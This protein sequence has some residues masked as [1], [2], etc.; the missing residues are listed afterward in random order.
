MPMESLLARVS[1]RWKITALVAASSLATAVL[2]RVLAGLGGAA[3]GFAVGLVLV[4]GFS[5]LAWWA[6]GLIVK[7]LGALRD[8]ARAIADGD[9]SAA[10][11]HKVEAGGELA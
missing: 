9:L 8:A 3:V 11:K 1:L 10:A 4:A 5:A 2:V 6:G 7:P